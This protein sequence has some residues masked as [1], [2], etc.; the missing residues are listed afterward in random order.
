MV[1]LNS[2][3]LISFFNM[4]T[5]DE[6]FSINADDNLPNAKTIITY[7]HIHAQKLT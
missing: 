4:V 5:F 7:D 1:T 6:I 2:D 3:Y